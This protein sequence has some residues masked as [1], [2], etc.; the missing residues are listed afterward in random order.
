MD[1]LPDLDEE[2]STEGILSKFLPSYEA[3][4]NEEKARPRGEVGENGSPILENRT[5]IFYPLLK[6]FGCNLAGI[7]FMKLIATVLT[8]ASPT[9][10]SALITFVSSNGE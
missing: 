5:N 7:A 8:F 9:L 2:N 1:E 4:V 10:L 6:T 3:E